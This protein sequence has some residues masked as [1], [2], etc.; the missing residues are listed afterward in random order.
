[1]HRDFKPDNVLL[2][3]DGEVHVA[4]FGLARLTD[5]PS[6]PDVEASRTAQGGLTQTGDVFGTPAYM[7]PEQLLG[8]PIDERADQ[9]S[10]CVALWEAIYGERPFTGGTGTDH[11]LLAR[12]DAIASGCEPPRRGD[13]PMWIAQILL[14]G[15]K[16][17]PDQRWPSLQTLLDAIAARRAPRR[18]PSRLAVVVFAVGL[19][20]A[21]VAL[22]RALSPSQAGP[23]QPT[24]RSDV[25]RAAISPDGSMLALV[26]GESLVIREIGPHEVE[27]VIVDHG[28]D[29]AP[30]SWSPDGKHLLAGLVPEVAPLIQDALIEIG[31]GV[32]YKLPVTGVASFLSSTEIAVTSYR[33]RSIT[34]LPVGEGAAITRTCEVPGDYTFLWSLTGLPDGTMV[35]QTRKGDAWGLVILRRD[36]Q[37]RARFAGEQISSVAVSETSPSVAV[38]DTGTIVAFTTD[39]V[40]E[41]LE[42]SL[43]G[44]VL[45]RRSVSVSGDL[46]ILGR[47]HGTDY[48]AARALKTRLVSVH[49]GTRPTKYISVNGKASF[50][51]APDG[52]TVAWIDGGS[53]GRGPLRLSTLQGTPWTDPKV[54]DDASMVDWSPDGRSLAVLVDDGADATIVVVDRNGA[55]LH[56]V[57]LHPIQRTAAPVWLNDHQVAAQTDDRA[58]YRWYD[59]DT[60][61]QGDIVD[62]A[63]GSTYW[64][65]RSP[66]D[67]TLAM[68]R[69]GPPE[70]K[71]A[72]HLW[73]KPV[74]QPVRPLH[75]PDAV[76][77]HLLPSWS[78]SGEL[79]VRALETG[80]VSRVA[81]SGELISIAQLGK[82]PVSRLFDHHV[83]TR[84]NGDLLAV[85][86]DLSITVLDVGRQDASR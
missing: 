31:R 29:D 12:V 53:N 15:L 61:K 2:G 41:I 80:T 54:L 67:G 45:T 1:M 65:A 49:P 74:G 37:V 30:I 9:F 38:S 78:P 21:I 48:V 25:K 77:Y 82:I 84:A 43:D 59:L 85:E 60:G 68:W 22:T 40:S 56:R 28:I 33:K 79:L 75:V 35:V 83:M 10:F 34:I 76:Q 8:R 23:I 70:A 26:V 19:A 13:R 55:V 44:A 6:T 18:W 17:D 51:L 46:E 57:P 62:R 3:D 73:V 47:R 20:T 58:T 16:A 72:E 69:N 24:Q 71:D 81:D 4:D 66:R 11:S 7:A 63:H 52:E 64:L 36:C 27:S 50:S 42:I 86:I 14:R 39:P 5:F 32:Q